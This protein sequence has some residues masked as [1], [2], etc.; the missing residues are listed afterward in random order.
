MSYSIDNTPNRDRRKGMHYNG[1]F[2]LCV[3]IFVFIVVG[4]AVSLSI[5]AC[6]H[7]DY[8]TQEAANMM[9]VET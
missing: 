9:P 2:I 8:Y 5:R 1:V 6:S 7:H 4:F 3:A